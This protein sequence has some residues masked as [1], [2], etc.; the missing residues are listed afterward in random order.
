MDKSMIKNMRVAETNDNAL[1]LICTDGTDRSLHYDEDALFI[2]ISCTDSCSYDYWSFYGFTALYEKGLI[3]A[4][5][6]FDYSGD[7]IRAISKYGKA[8]KKE[9]LLQYKHRIVWKREDD[10]K[11][12]TVDEISKALG[13]KVKVIGDDQD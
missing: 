8:L 13:Y 12:M 9:D 1:L 2:E 3:I 11:E 6:E 5:Y 4:L 10:Y 7:V